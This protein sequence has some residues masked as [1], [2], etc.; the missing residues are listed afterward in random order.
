MVTCL[1]CQKEFQNLSSHVSKKHSI[2]RSQYMTMYPGA[3]YVSEE[4]SQ[5]FSRRAELM[6]ATLKLD[7]LD[8]YHRVRAETCKRMREIKGP[9]FLHSD[10]TKAK[11]K[12]THTGL[13]REPHTEATKALLSKIKTG[14]PLLLSDEAKAEKSR[15]QKE[16][17]ALRKLDLVEFE[18]YIKNLS[19]N[20]IEYIKLHGIALPKKGRKTNIE[21]KFAAYLE[22][23]NIKYT[24][25]YLLDGKYYDFYLED[26][27]LLV[28]VDG[29]YWHRLPPAIKNDLEKHIIAKDRSLKLLRINNLDWQ[30]ELIFEKDYSIIIKHNFNIINKRTTEC[31]NY[32]ISISQI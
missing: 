19:T 28:E 3:K 8:K 27:Q 11:M 17:W 23:N 13:S 7:D 1:I 10:A 31:L 25:Q 30:P 21:T 5:S 2:N 26:F 15:K 12:E 4:L 22:L 14:K 18:K 6:H 32:A 29:E 20:R 24:Y 9:D 16:Q